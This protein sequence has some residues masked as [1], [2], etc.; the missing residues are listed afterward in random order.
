M[1]ENTPKPTTPN[2]AKSIWPLYAVI[3]ISLAPIVASWL[4]F[5]FVEFKPGTDTT[6]Y[7]ELLN[8]QVPMPATDL[9]A[10][11][12]L[13]G[14]P[15]DFNSIKRKFAYIVVSDSANCD[16][17]CQER[18]FNLR[19]LRITT[20]KERER[21]TLLWLITEAT[22]ADT[23][24][25]PDPALLANHP[26][27]TVLRVNASNLAFLPIAAGQTLYG[28]IWIKD[29]VH[30]VMMRYPLGA[31]PLKMRKDL[32]KVIYASRGIQLKTQQ[33]Q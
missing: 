23:T 2:K 31:D 1:T 26:D 22:V 20:G 15:Y 9:I 28:Q 5:N 18:L 32:S 10:A 7:G 16:L 12:T 29:G 25:A 27:L 30:N 17:I 4:V 11:K 21:L 3:G 14:K 24:K 8:P 33:G 19:Q 13:D 6:N